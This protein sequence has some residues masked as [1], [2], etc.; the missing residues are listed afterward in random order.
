MCDI[1][2]KQVWQKELNSF[3][4]I[5]QQSVLEINSYSSEVN[6]VCTLIYFL[7]PAI[8]NTFL[9]SSMSALTAQAKGLV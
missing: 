7:F 9:V 3:V 6:F 2:Y 8:P 1:W 5:V 4:I